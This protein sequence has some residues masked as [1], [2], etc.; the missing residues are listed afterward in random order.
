MR[1]GVACVAFGGDFSAACVVFCV[2]CF[3]GGGVSI[4]ILC[5]SVCESK[6]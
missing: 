1:C 3:A 2:V 5:E 6:A 4:N